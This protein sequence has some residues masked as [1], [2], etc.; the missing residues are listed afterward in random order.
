MAFYTLNE[1][2]AAATARELRDDELGFIG[3]GTDGRAYTLAVGIPMVAA[4]LAQLSHAPNFTIFWNNL[5]SPELDQIPPYLTQDYLTK[6]P[7]S[8][9]PVTCEDKNEM[10]ANERFDVCF[11][12]APQIDRFGNMNITAIGDYK[13]PKVRLVGCLAQ[14]DH[15][16]FVKRPI[17][18]TDL[19]KRSFVERVDFITSVGYLEGGDSRA[20]AGLRPFGPWKVITDK[21]I[22][23]FDNENKE[24][25]LESLHPGV[26]LEEVLDNMGFRPLV[27]EK[28]PNT[29]EP[30]EE[31]I[32]IIR[33]TIDPNN[34]LLRA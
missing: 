6:W 10:L 20:K 16:A 29:Q 14:P 9:Q 31:Q 17:I 25:Q 21:C 22:L 28:V 32:K 15:L 1:L 7:C 27:P 24:M 8:F 19:K 23:N 12:S 30:T 5:L 34:S 13:K 3:V 33:E 11:D 26:T 4:R 18:I 2:M